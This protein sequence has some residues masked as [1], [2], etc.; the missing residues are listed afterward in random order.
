MTARILPTHRLAA[1]PALATACTFGL[2]TTVAAQDQTRQP[3]TAAARDT[4]QLSLTDIP[5]E[6]GPRDP[7]VA[8][9]GKRIWF[10][11]QRGNFVGFYTPADRQ[12]KRIEIDSGTHPHTVIVDE[13]GNAW[14]AGNRN[15]MVGRIDG[16]TL[17]I[18]R[19]AMP[20][21]AARDPHTMDFDANGNLWFTLQHSNMV[22]YLDHATGKVDLITLKT[23]QSRPYGLIVAPDGQVWLDLFG[24]NKIAV[25]NPDTRAVRE[26]ALPDERTRPRRIARTNDGAI[27]YTDYSRGYLGRLDPANGSVK[28][29]EL[30]GKAGSLPYAMTVDDQDRLWVVE[31]GVQPNQLV[32]FDPST[33]KFF[34]HTNVGKKAPNAVRHMVFDPNT[35]SIW[36]GSDQGALGQAIVPKG[37][38]TVF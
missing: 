15:G 24:T 18:T 29:Y 19:F 8:P 16:K 4:V 14:Y 1:F 5:W 33:E 10:V 12:F 7:Y 9:D 20:D 30:P 2:S 28:E 25:I 31:T 34:G 13:Q 27:W 35:R 6:G 22:G 32:G 36:F 23:P 21:E 37:Q 11:G 38:R 3:V 26:F 17:E